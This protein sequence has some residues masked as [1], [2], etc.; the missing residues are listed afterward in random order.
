M[1]TGCA[2]IPSMPG[3]SSAPTQ[4]PLVVVQTVLVTV[5]PTEMPT[6]TPTPTSLPAAAPQVIV[7]TAT[8]ASGE[9]VPTTGAAGE[10]SPS[11]TLPADAG[12]GLF[13]T[14]TRSGDHFALRCQP[15]T[16]TFG[17]STDNPYVMGVDFYYRI[18][19]RLSVSISTWQWAGSMTSDKHG[20]FT[21]DFASSRVDPDLRS[22]RA[23]FDYQF[24]GLNKQGEAL[25]RSARIVKQITYTIDC[26]D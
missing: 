6:M 24:V 12:G 25:G 20:N 19:D 4:T 5:V 26:T 11:A 1:L 16:I 15:D 23:W 9:T 2:S 8:P 22:H 13:T 17:V 14:L 3:V 21:I 10:V 7:V 18:E